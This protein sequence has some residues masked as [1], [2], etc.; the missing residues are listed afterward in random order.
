MRNCP[1]NPMSSSPYSVA[2]SNKHRRARGV[3]PCQGEMPMFTAQDFRVKATESGG[4]LKNSNVP[5]EIRKFKQSMESFGQLARNE[6]WLADN[7]DKMIRSQDAL[8]KDEPVEKWLDSEAVGQ[9]EEHIL[10]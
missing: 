8:S 7:F 6:D 5:S 9:M 4:S 2:A 3:R 10:R 1:R